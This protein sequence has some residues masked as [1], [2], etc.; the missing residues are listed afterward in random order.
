MTQMKSGKRWIFSNVG[1][2]N[3]PHVRVDSICSCNFWVRKETIK[4][5]QTPSVFSSNINM[6]NIE[7]ESTGTVSGVVR[8]CDTDVSHQN[9]TDDLNLAQNF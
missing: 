3:T 7:T 1:F 2:K 5:Q 8:A 4:R 6:D 9:R